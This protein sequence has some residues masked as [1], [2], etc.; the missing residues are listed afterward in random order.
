MKAIRKPEKLQDLYITLT[1]AP[2]L[3]KSNNL[4]DILITPYEFSFLKFCL[5]H[6]Y[7]NALT[8]R[9]WLSFKYY[10]VL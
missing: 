6:G 1:F 4:Q 9:I 10:F 3:M 5:S 7:G 8:E 2:E